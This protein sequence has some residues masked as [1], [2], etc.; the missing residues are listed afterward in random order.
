ME[1]K[2]RNRCKTSN[3]RW[4]IIWDQN[5]CV[6]GRLIFNEIKKKYMCDLI[7]LYH[8]LIYFITCVEIKLSN[9]LVYQN[10]F[11]YE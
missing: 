6:I 9:N 7:K 8:S 5:I 10:L 4:L 3:K 2:K 1:P 11:N